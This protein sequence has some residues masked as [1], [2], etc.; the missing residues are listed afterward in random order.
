MKRGETKNNNSNFQKRLIFWMR[1]TAFCLGIVVLLAGVTVLIGWQFDITGLQT[2]IPGFAPMNPL[3]AIEFILCGI[4][5]CV[6]FFSPSRLA[7]EITLFISAAIIV[8]G[9]LRLME[10]FGFNIPVDQILFAGKLANYT[11]A[12]RVPPIAAINFILIGLAFLVVD[13]SY[14]GRSLAQYLAILNGS[15]AL[16][17]LLAYLFGSSF[18]SITNF[19]SPLAFLGAINFILLTLAILFLRPNIGITSILIGQNAGGMLARRLAPL[20]LIIPAGLAYAGNY[21]VNA[22]LFDFQLGLAIITV[23]NIILFE[24]F[25]L[26]YFSVVD[27]AE[28]DREK[29]QKI[30]A[31]AKALD[32]ALLACIGDGVVATDRQGKVILF[33]V[34]AEAMFGIKAHQAIGK[35]ASELW[36]IYDSGGNVLSDKDKPLQVSIKTGKTIFS[37]VS[38]PYYYAIDHKKFPVSITVSPAVFNGA[39][40]GVINVFRDISRDVEIDLAKSEFVSF[41]SHQLRTPTTAI[42]WQ[43]ESFLDDYGDKLDSK[44]KDIIKDI[45]RENRQVSDLITDFLS[46]AKIEYGI[47]PVAS[48]PIDLV[49]IVDSIVEEQYAAQISE[50]NISVEKKI[51]RGLCAINADSDL[52]KLIVDNLVS[53]AIKYSSAGGKIV[54]ELIRVQAGEMAGNRKL[55][56]DACIL[57]VADTGLGIPAPEQDKIFSKF[58]RTSIA[59]DKKIPGTGLGLYMVKLFIQKMGGDIWFV[60]EENKGTKFFVRI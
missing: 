33:N 42:G 11:P 48:V 51:D 14:R 3:S 38:N 24:L 17:M 46:V 58:Y 23:F 35:S 1:Q 59:K 36:S 56:D 41:A 2:I 53:N 20:I 30:I 18:S 44:E 6:L 22:G 4:T 52:Y 55:P 12:S 45:Y 43:I 57:T 19:F 34:Q 16:F 60:S 26:S 39:I 28:A 29:N 25:N 7:R 13:K 50:K 15:F 21:L 9:L 49:R 32:D 27:A 40:V 5:V 47:T 37:S 54:I 8:L 10:V 31:Q